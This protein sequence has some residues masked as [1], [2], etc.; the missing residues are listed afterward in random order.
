MK[1][2]LILAELKGYVTAMVDSYDDRAERNPQVT[3]PVKKVADD[4][5]KILELIVDM[6]GRK[7]TEAQVQIF[8][9]GGT[10]SEFTNII[11][12]F[13]SQKLQGN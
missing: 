9:N 12:K 7:D 13:N 11:K 1:E 6:Q 5:Y 10:D 3:V 4:I 8:I 2:S